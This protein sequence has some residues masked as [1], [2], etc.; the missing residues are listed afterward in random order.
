MAG[1]TME[2]SLNN[3]NK[4]IVLEA[5]D[6][7]FNRR[8]Y[9][10]AERFWSP[11]YVQHSAH[12]EPGRDGLFN[13]IRSL[14]NTLHYEN[15]LILAAGDYVMLHGRFSGNGRF[16]AWIAADIV[17][18][19]NGRLAEHWDVLQDEATR[20]ESKSG[21][22]MFGT[23]F[24]EP[25]HEYAPAASASS[26]TVEEAR[27]IVAPLY[28]A[29]NQ[30]GKKDVAALLAKAS[31]PDY[32]SYSTNEDWLTRDQLTEVFKTI[33][34]VTPDL[35]WTIK[36]IQTF[37]DQI[38]V[39]GE[40]TGTPVRDFWGAKPTGKSFKTMA[41]DVFTVKNGKLASAY[42]VENWMTALQ[43]ISG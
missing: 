36:D 25:E 4:A 22:P 30:P 21:L 26:L 20:E 2:E 19:E 32:R 11:D 6:T 40:A 27:R 10:A 7:L 24:A 9:A 17:R 28:D 42:H 43:Q 33:G 13:L 18:M 14:P 38:V 5:F 31:N 8:D 3:Q 39:R 12:I 23:S 34:S 37:G 16:R 29:L 15:A 41:I 35:R 1:V